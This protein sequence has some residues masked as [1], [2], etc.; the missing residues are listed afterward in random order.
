MIYYILFVG[1]KLRM[2]AISRRDFNIGT[3][4]EPLGESVCY[5][6]QEFYGVNLQP[7]Q[8]FAIPID[9][10]CLWNW[11][12]PDLDRRVDCFDIIEKKC[13]VPG[14]SEKMTQILRGDIIPY[15]MGGFPWSEEKSSTLEIHELGETGG[16]I[17]V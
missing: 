12:D 11:S 14:L 8:N 7:Y 5:L 17:N 4:E 16:L 3:S 10:Y 1:S 9:L 13:C 15:K 2:E 6:L